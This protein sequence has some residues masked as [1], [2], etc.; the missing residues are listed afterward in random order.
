MQKIWE[1]WQALIPPLR[2]LLVFVVLAFGAAFFFAPKAKVV[3]YQE[4]SYATSSDSRLYFNNIRSYYY[5]IDNL[6]KKPMEILRL[7]RLGSERDQG[8]LNF[9][10]IRY[11][12]GDQYFVLA[13]PGSDFEQCDSLRLVFSEYP[14]SELHRLSN[15][16]IHFE[17]AAKVY[18]SLIKQESIYLCCG[19]DTLKQLYQDQAERL[20]AEI[21]L[22]DY[23]KLT[24]KN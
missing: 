11:P 1:K 16:E 14:D 17:I 23:F 19:R 15:A 2:W 5:H 9:A 6:S 20:D 18:S 13:E 24:L 8:N 22:E 12:A 3:N 7:K 21:A 10:L 4:L